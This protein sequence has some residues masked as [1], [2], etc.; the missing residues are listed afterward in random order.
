M[1]LSGIEP[2]AKQPKP[3]LRRSR[4]GKTWHAVIIA[5]LHVALPEHKVKPAGLLDNLEQQNVSPKKVSHQRDSTTESP[6]KKAR[7]G[8]FERHP[9]LTLSKLAWAALRS[10]DKSLTC[11]GLHGNKHNPPAKL[12]FCACIGSRITTVIHV[13]VTIKRPLNTK[14]LKGSENG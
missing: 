2:I 3:L 9:R 6:W 12:G 14:K 1:G 8:F 11:S 4:T 13:A 7:P 10:P 5:V